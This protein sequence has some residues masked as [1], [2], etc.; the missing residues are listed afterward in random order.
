MRWPI[1]AVCLVVCL[2]G[3]EP[4]ACWVPLIPS[5]FYHL[6]HCVT[7][8][9]ASC[10]RTHHRWVH[11]SPA[12][13]KEV[14]DL[15]HFPSK[16]SCTVIACTGLTQRRSEGKSRSAYT[17]DRHFAKM[18]H[19]FLKSLSSSALIKMDSIFYWL[20]LFFKNISKKACILKVLC[21]STHNINCLWIN[22]AVLKADL[23]AAAA[24]LT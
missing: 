22:V 6:Q 11:R 20:F 4:S 13:V 9:C 5:P 18:R 8:L 17:V 14:W 16:V 23:K 24:R 12:E 21:W 19:R 10:A 15:I 1:R 7:L 2:R 3:R